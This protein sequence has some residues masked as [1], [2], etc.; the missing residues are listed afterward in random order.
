[1]AHKT[2]TAALALLLGAAGCGDGSGGATI[3]HWSPASPMLG[4]KLANTNNPEGPAGTI[5]SITRLG[6]YANVT[7]EYPPEWQ[8]PNANPDPQGQPPVNPSDGVELAATDYHGLAA[9]RRPVLK[10]DFRAQLDAS[11]SSIIYDKCSPKSDSRCI[12][13]HGNSV[14][15]SHCYPPGNY[16][17]VP[18][19][20]AGGYGYTQGSGGSTSAPAP[21]AEEDGAHQ[22][23][24]TN[25]Q[26]AS[27]DEADFVKNDAN[28][29]FVL[30]T[31]GVHVIDAWPAPETHEVAKLTV[32]GEPRRLLLEQNRLVVYTRMQATDEG[33]AGSSNPSDQGCT[34]GYD[35]RFQSEGGHT[36]VLVFDVAD[37]SHPSELMRYE[38]SGGFVAS[39][40]VGNV[41][42]TVVHDTGATQVPGV[43]LTVSGK[44]YAELEEAYAR[45]LATNDA[46]VDALSDEYFLPWVRTTAPGAGAVTATSG[47]NPALASSAARGGSFVS[48][49]AFDLTQLAPPTR[50]I[51][52]SSAG[53]VYSSA[54]GLYL[55]VDRV[56]ELDPSYGYYYGGGQPT[57]TV[58]HKFALDGVATRY[59]GSALLPGHILNQFAMDEY[60]GVLRVASSLGWVPDPSVTSAVTTFAERAGTLVRV[61]QIGG[62]APD[63]DIRA[64][65]F[66]ADRAFVVTFK[67]TDPLFVFDL[68]NPA[69]PVQ[70][71]ELKIPGFSTYMQRLDANHL[72]A[73]GFTADDM[74]SFA[75]FN[76]IQI[77]MFDITD[78]ANPKLLFR[79]VIGT[80]G[81][82]S[83]AL[84]NHLA[85]NY[86]AP[87]KLLALPMTVCEGGGNGTYGDK[88]TFAGLM[89]FDISLE[90]GITEH[91]RLPFADTTQTPAGASCDTW[92]AESSSLVKRSIFMDDWVYALSDQELKVAGLG[93]MATPVKTLPLVTP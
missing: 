50:T 67:K 46:A 63:E 30:G 65:R 25:N 71:G 29:V 43:V 7:V 68:S 83:E 48:L 31:D 66:D 22:Y 74:G 23:S 85:F 69:A 32:P 60:D 12:D 53:Y 78:L 28:T 5:T 35:C 33:G 9:L 13:A 20:A 79:N 11:R 8:C 26:V 42:Y 41:V 24:T 18:G 37:P 62:I 89:A 87:K 44:S 64:V 93:S 55:A 14:D 61:G 56:A 40:R 86:F 54:T 1:M 10:A 51:V 90:T 59:R 92:W 57:D 52:A 45:A 88:L 27:V 34:Y 58:V 82:A 17:G 77:Q 72:L 84:T 49:T 2:W 16:G 81:S 75:F 80:R 39:R 38:L 6:D 36:M 15:W 21:S 76:G 91:G 19:A 3:V 70:L 73:I 4:D 47:D